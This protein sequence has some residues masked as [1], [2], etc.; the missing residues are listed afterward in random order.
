M[1]TRRARIKAVI[2]LPPRRKNNE[3][4]NKSNQA[5]Q[6]S[7]KKNQERQN[8]NKSPVKPTENFEKAISPLVSTLSQ[9]KTP[10][11]LKKEIS[12][13]SKSPS[14]LVSPKVVKKIP[15]IT[16]TSLKTTL[17]S[18]QDSPINKI[19]SPG[20]IVEKLTPSR[21][22][23]NTVEKANK[24]SND[25]IEK[26]IISFNE[27]T[28]CKRDIAKNILSTIFI[29]SANDG[30]NDTAMDGIMPLNGTRSA[31][32]T[33]HILKDEIISESAEVLFDPIVPLPSPGKVRPKLRPVPRLGPLRRNSVQGSASESEDE[34]RRALLNS[35]VNTPA[36]SR[37]RHDSQTSAPNRDLNR[38]RNDSVS[39]SISQ[40]TGQQ[41]TSSPNKEKNYSKIRR[42]E[43]SRRMAAIRRRRENIRRS[44]LTMYDLIFYNPSENPIVPDQEEIQA[45]EAD[46]KDEA[47]LKAAEE[48]ADDPPEA[49][50][51]PVPQIKLGPNGEIILDEK[52]L[53]IKST[54]GKRK[55]SSVVREGAW[56]G[57]AGA[58]GRY[59]RAARTADWS[60]DETVRF[61]RALAALGTDFS[62]MVNLFPDRSRRD[63]KLKFKKEE[64]MNAYLV[65]KAMRSGTCWDAAGLLEEF[66][67]E[68]A[69]ATEKK[70]AEH[71]EYLKAKRDAARRETAAKE[72]GMRRSLT[73]KALEVCAERNVKNG[74]YDY[75]VQTADQIIQRAYTQKLTRSRERKEKAD[76]KKLKTT[77]RKVAIPVWKPKDT[78]A[79]ITPTAQVVDP[80]TISSL[81][82]TTL[83]KVP[84]HIETPS[85]ATSVSS[86][87]SLPQNIESGSLVV[88][89]VNDPNAPSKK[90]LQTYIAN[91]SG[92]LTPVSLP[93][94]FLNS[95]VGY[96]K[97]G[98]PKSSVSGS[99]QLFSPVMSNPEHRTSATP[100]VIQFTPSPNKRQI[101]SSNSYTIMQ[102]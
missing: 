66:E 89:T 39:S 57:G 27:K 73:A 72:I 1:S 11:L 60:H 54:S 65:E 100:N 10:D 52:S 102:L 6:D 88:L 93:P 37:L 31:A 22:A 99:P 63:L 36:H 5:S 20:I 59:S 38:V 40:A 43:T 58:G 42:Q 74:K 50:E 61:Y 17:L 67:E 83:T 21:I 13:I 25:V 23:N 95:V 70:I 33:I 45:K 86:V 51:A 47:A 41:P 79:T 19:K 49:E 34:S 91:D 2:S 29:K 90:M 92:Q 30:S 26:N 69:A 18:T 77:P 4:N 32:K 75:K 78:L 71:E 80:P 53:V 56:T 48:E 14:V 68:R 97:K 87:T 94:N 62:L 98:T 44:D 3:N 9:P 12:H 82:V 46:K 7:G 15:V 96:M 85:P 101:H 84:R 28:N 76:A 16:S 55:V 8:H 35:G 81:D 24:I 64:R